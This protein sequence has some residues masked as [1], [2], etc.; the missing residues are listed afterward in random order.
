MQI[1]IKGLEKSYGEKKALQQFSVSLQ[2]GIYG[3]LG[4]N[5]AGKS[6]LMN[7]LTDNLERDKGQI[8]V[9]QKDI[10]QLGSAYRRKVGYMPQQ[11]GYYDELS[12]K[13][14]LL[15]MAHLKEI[16]RRQRK[17]EVERVLEAVNLSDV[18][19]KKIGG[20]SGGMKQRVMLAQ[21]L[22][23]EPELLILDEPTAGVDPKERIRLRNLIAEL[24]QNKIILLATH[25]VSDIECIADQV[26]LMKNGELL[27]IDTPQALM[28]ELHGKVWEKNCTRVELIQLQKKYPYGN[29][30]QRKEGT[31]FRVVQDD[32]EEGFHVVEEDIGLED[33]YMYWIG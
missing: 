32:A 20:F 14:F 7:L 12:A 23:G 11:Q 16:P 19:R 28:Q 4:Q 27:R 33:V 13:A 8:L 1:E 6:T 26:L 5:G 17:N 21:A 29:I 25:I 3:I 2:P 24:A 30:H 22:L 10:L 18:A 15:Y 9:G 31:V